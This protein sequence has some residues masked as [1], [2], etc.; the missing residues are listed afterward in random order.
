MVPVSSMILQYI[1]PLSVGP[2][3]GERNCEA[4]DSAVCVGFVHVRTRKRT[5]LASLFE[6]ADVGE[7]A[8]VDVS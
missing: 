3:T 7:N 2:V 1:H 8:S 5:C 6:V 4:C